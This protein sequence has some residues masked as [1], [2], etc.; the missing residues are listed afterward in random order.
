MFIN[1]VNIFYLCMFLISS[2]SQADPL[3]KHSSALSRDYYYL[4]VDD[5]YRFYQI[6]D[7]V[8]GEHENH[9]YILGFAG[10]SFQIQIISETEEIAYLLPSSGYRIQSQALDSKSAKMT[11]IVEVTAEWVWID[12]RFSA[13]PYGE[14]QLRVTKA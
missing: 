1:R 8:G 9:Y 4:R 13:H 2:Y 12:L 7:K 11:Y 6:S 3:L 5:K 10:E 14:Y